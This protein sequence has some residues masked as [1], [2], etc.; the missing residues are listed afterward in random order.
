MK[1]W[2]PK[3]L[4]YI[5]MLPILAIA[6]VLSFVWNFVLIVDMIWVNIVRRYKSG[7]KEIKKDDK[8]R[9]EEHKQKAYPEANQKGT[10]EGRNLQTK[11][12]TKNLH[13]MREPL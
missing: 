9:E 8:K 7:I 3:I 4:A 6:L 2:I 12:L 13:A 11:N 1:K 5:I 10:E